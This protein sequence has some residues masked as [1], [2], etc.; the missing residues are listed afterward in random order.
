MKCHLGAANSLALL[1][2]LRGQTNITCFF[3][4]LM[5]LRKGLW[6]FFSKLLKQVQDKQTA[7]DETV[8]R[9]WTNGKAEIAIAFALGRLLDHYGI[10]QSVD[11]S[12][13]F[14]TVVGVTLQ[15]NPFQRP[16]QRNSKHPMAPC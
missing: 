5:A 14:W 4:F 10:H 8:V 6:D 16:V 2:I 7:F 1:G 15:E 3:F 11:N 13:E 9:E 12:I